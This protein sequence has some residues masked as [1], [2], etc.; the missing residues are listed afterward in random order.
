MKIHEYQA[1]ELLAQYGIPTQDGICV[2]TYE[3]AKIAVDKMFERH[4]KLVI[5]AQIH[6]GG[7]GK[8]G[9]VKLANNQAEGYEIAKNMLG[10]QLVTKQTG[11]EGKRVNKILV[12]DAVQIKKE[13]YI[14]IMMDGSLGCPIIVASAE[15][16]TEIEEVAHD[17]PDA[18]ITIPISPITGLKEFHARNIAKM[19]NIPSE[20]VKDFIKMLKNMY[21]L[22]IEK[23][24]SMLE[25]NPLIIDGNNQL[26][27]IDAKFGF[28]EN[29]LFRHPDIMALRDIEEEDAKEVEAAESG[30]SYISLDG[31]IGCMVNGAGLAMA[32]MDIIKAYGGRPANFLDVGGTASAQKV[33]A[34]FKILLS[35]K[36]VKCILVNIF[37]GIMKCDIIAEGILTAAKEVNLSV[38]LVVRLDGTN[39][40]EGKA[41]LAKSDLKIIAADGLEDAAKLAVKHGGGK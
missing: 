18:I 11:L 21:R 37:G 7:R 1:K 30:L 17:N 39:V 9:G 26:N 6:S 35:D 41:I 12:T 24:C 38:P 20:L 40:K 10:M 23:D 31:N 8:G 27:A 3:D 28:D 15:G 32:T 36:N 14:C 25:I 34:A 29:A 13:F 19:I 22:F 4:P 2:C 5:K 33:A 16:G